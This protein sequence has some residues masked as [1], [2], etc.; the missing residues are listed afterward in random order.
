MS[1]QSIN[2]WIIT[3]FVLVGCTNTTE[4]VQTQL[5]NQIE[6]T[7]GERLFNDKCTLCHLKT[8]PTKKQRRTMSAPEMQSVV[9]ALYMQ[10]SDSNGIINQEESIRFIIDYVFFP[11]VTKSLL[12]QIPGRDYGLMPSLK[13]SVNTD[14]LEQISEYILSTFKPVEANQ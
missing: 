5:A 13:G 12:K 14:E 11:D 10:F 2:H 6:I 3:F 4:Q 7:D 8:K 1:S 9:N